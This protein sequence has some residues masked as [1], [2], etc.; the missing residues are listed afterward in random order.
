MGFV[1]EVRLGSIHPVVIVKIKIILKIKTFYWKLPILLQS[2]VWNVSSYHIMNKTSHFLDQTKASG[3]VHEGVIR[4]LIWP[5]EISVTA[6]YYLKKKIEA[7]VG[8]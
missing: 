2:S 7:W 3:C 8:Q 4:C 1:L 6:Y 5:F